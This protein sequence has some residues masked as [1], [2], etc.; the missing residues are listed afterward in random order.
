[1]PRSTIFAMAEGLGW[2]FA[3]CRH[4]E[5]F[6]L[7]ALEYRRIVTSK[8]LQIAKVLRGG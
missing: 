5:A 3:L 7:F 8:Q 1:V 6:K 4:H 2:V